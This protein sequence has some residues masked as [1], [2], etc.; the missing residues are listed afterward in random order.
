MR[1]KGSKTR[2]GFTLIELLV[3][4]SIIAL[5]VSILLPSLGKAKSLA[6]Q[7]VCLTSV[8]AQLKGVHMYAAEQNGLL[9]CGS[10]NP[11]KYPG[12][13]SLP[14]I[15]SLA[16]FQLWLGLNQEFGAHGALVDR[17]LVQ[18]ES[19]YCPE[20]PTADPKGD[21]PKMRDK[22]T[23]FVWC[24]YLYRQLD[25]QAADPPKRSIDNLGKN[26]SGDRVSALIFDIQCEMVWQGL[27]QKKIHE[28]TKCSLG[29]VNGGAKTVSN[30][31]KALTLNGSTS[32]TYKRL[33]QMLQ[34]ADTK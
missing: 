21:W 19:F 4:I 18:L 1:G 17:R 2:R 31:D 11:L 3:V 9:I 14:P 26:Q 29:F 32:D 33:D 8:D 24:S 6:K 27:P 15:N 12:Q 13:G 22:T 10:D 30:E 23:D 28:G 7:A 20:D 34:A 25:G 16:S 5:L